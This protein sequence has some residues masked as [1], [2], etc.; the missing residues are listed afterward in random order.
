VAPLACEECGVIAKGTAEGWQ[1]HLA[2]DPRED[3]APFTVFYCPVCA[4]N[5]FGADPTERN[6]ESST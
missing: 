2:Y 5:E 3:E 6:R 1:G 4:S